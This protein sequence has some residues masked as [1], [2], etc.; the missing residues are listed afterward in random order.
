MNHRHEHADD[1]HN[2]PVPQISWRDL[3][4][5]YKPMLAMDYQ[6]KAS[7]N[8]FLDRQQ[9]YALFPLLSQRNLPFP[10]VEV[11]PY[12]TCLQVRLLTTK[13]L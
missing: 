9:F 2:L 6:P 7:L 8:Y 10:G 11:Y 1:R 3:T 5:K 12:Q 13:V 4:Q